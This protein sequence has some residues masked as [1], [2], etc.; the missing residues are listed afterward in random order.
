ML[1]GGIV[2]ALAGALR[3]VAG[4]GP[5]VFRVIQMEKEVLGGGKITRAMSKHSIRC[6]QSKDDEF[7]SRQLLSLE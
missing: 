5:G 4:S 6:I 1:Q 3:Q 2:G 7:L